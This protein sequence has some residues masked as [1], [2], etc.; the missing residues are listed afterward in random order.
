MS[1]TGGIMAGVGLL[2]SIGSA[3]IG[4]NAA[5]NAASTQAAA[6]QQAAQLQYQESQ[7]ALQ[8]QE[9][10][11]GQSQ[12]NEAPFLQSGLA[13][14][15]NLDYLL[16]IQPPTTQGATSGTPGAFTGAG[17][18][19]GGSATS[20]AGSG[21]TGV[22]GGGTGTTG[23]TNLSSMVNP[24]LGA[25][26]SLSQGYQG[27]PFVAPT[28]AQAL[29]SPGEQSQ[30]QLGE[31][32]M[33]QSAA[34]QGNLLT[35]GTAQ[36]L[37]SYAQNLA[38]TNYQNTY[39]NAYNTYASG[40]NQFQNQQTNE[41]NRLASL[42][43]QGQTTA[44]TLATIGSNT[45]NAVSNNLLQTGQNI[46]QQINNA[47]AANASGIIGSANAWSGALG[48]TTNNLSNL[49]LLSGLYGGNIGGATTGSQ[50]T[51]FGNGSAP[52]SSSGSY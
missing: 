4:S 33:Q 6:A 29:A 13:G 43:G 5:G 20:P 36:A 15:A 24:S 46:G 38:S 50:T 21:T 45:A 19:I 23:S 14:Q 44:N 48:N 32:A 31:Q 49:A 12:A 40:Y 34:A 27:G 1:V 25:F 52:Y 2:G 22:S 41:Y 8:F 30:L 16:G 37:N 9:G 11:Y 18:G 35:G 7:N 42:A 10:T 3:A 39:N 26:G 17:V 28:A 47:G 51:T